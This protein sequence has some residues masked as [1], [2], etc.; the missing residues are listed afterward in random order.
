MTSHA[1]ALGADQCHRERAVLVGEYRTK[2]DDIRQ[3]A[4]PVD[5]SESQMLGSDRPTDRPSPW[6]NSD[7]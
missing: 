2:E 4:G 1:T 7:A 3:E 6:P 5:L